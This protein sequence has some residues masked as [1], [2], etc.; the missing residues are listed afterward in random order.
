MVEKSNNGRN[1]LYVGGS[2][3]GNYT[4]IQDAI[5]N[6]SNGDTVYVYNG[7]YYENVVV[8]VLSINLTGEDRNDTIIDGGGS[9]DVI[10]MDI[11]Y[12][13]SI[14]GFHITNGSIGINLQSSSDTDIS[15]NIISNNYWGTD[16][17]YSSNLFLTNN[18][19]T[20]NS[21][22]GF[23]L[24]ECEGSNIIGN[25]FTSNGRYGVIFDDSA[26]C[27]IIDNYF[28][29]NHGCLSF[30]QSSGSCS[31]FNNTIS[32]NSG[33][34]IYFG[35]GC[36]NNQVSGNKIVDNDCGIYNDGVEGND[37]WNNIISNNNVG[38][39]LL[40]GS[41]RYN[42]ISKNVISN[43]TV[44]GFD[45]G[46]DANNNTIEK[47]DILNNSQGILCGY[48][49]VVKPRDNLFFYNSFIDNSHNAYDEG[50]N[51]W[52]NSTLKEGNYWDDYNGT[53]ANGDGIGD[54]PYNI[55]GGDNQDLYPLMQPYGSP[56]A[57][58]VYYAN[59]RTF[60][61]SSSYDIDGDIVL[62]EWDFDDGTTG[63]GKVITHVYYESGTYNVTLTVTDD[64]GY[65]DS[66]TKMIE[67]EA[68]YPP[69]P[70][71]INGPKIGKA[72][73]QYPYTFVSEDPNDDDVFYEIDWGDGDVDPWDGPHESN[74]IITREHSW[75][76]KGDYTIMARAKDVHGA[77][78]NWST[79][80][81]TM[82]KNKP[83]I[84]NYP[85][86]S[87]LFERFPM[88]QRLLIALGVNV[89]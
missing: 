32:Q 36:C 34:G 22:D 73:K 25:S 75:D 17:D 52:Y 20:N 27:D 11:A 38:I 81:V 43:N 2:G 24:N 59:N 56:I 31:I 51:T 39:R 58:F 15:S 8:D 65:Q 88:L 16:F 23:R 10:V 30:T 80:E 5:D 54:T 60:D 44:S 82:P 50:N 18:I 7:T 63:Q 37:I 35:M 42:T 9:G 84:I 13:S 48:G 47:N 46:V 1:I 78:G 33:T 74:T 57:D 62:Y 40:L 12:H 6:A 53:D 76:E 68:N 55:S 67:V 61:G 26:N 19:I 66:V 29:S 4:S 41:C 69:E 49:A 64:D 28:T 21:V 77:I 3:P 45:I 72:G 89:I 83:F 14:I 86:L 87:W 70:P 79:L 71:I 85:L